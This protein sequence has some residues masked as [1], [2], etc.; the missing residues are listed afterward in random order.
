MKTRYTLIATVLLLAQQAHATTLPQAAALAAQ[1]STGSTPGY[2]QLEQQSLQAQRAWLQGDSA[3][4]KREQLEKAK[5]T[6]KQADKA[7]LKSSG[8]DFNVKQNQQAGI[9]LL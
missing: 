5:Q 2:T 3:T 7:W 9:A 6:G 1:T 4:L 8:Y